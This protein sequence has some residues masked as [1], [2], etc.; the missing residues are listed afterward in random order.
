[1]KMGSQAK[2]HYLD[3]GTGPGI[4]MLHEISRCTLEIAFIILKLGGL[5]VLFGPYGPWSV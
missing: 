5:D 4:L 3:E 1:M 2:M